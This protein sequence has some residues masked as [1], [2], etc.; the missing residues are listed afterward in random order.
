MVDSAKRTEYLRLVAKI[1]A[2]QPLTPQENYDYTHKYSEYFGPTM[3]SNSGLSNKGWLH[4]SGG[5]AGHAVKAPPYNDQD[6][7]SDPMRKPPPS[8]GLSNK[9]WLHPST[10]IAGTPVKASGGGS[11]GGSFS[12]PADYWKTHAAPGMSSPAYNDQD[13]GSDPMRQPP[14]PFINDRD[15]GSDPMRQGIP[16][17][18]PEIHDPF[19]GGGTGGLITQLPDEQMPNIPQVTLSWHDFT[20]Q[21]R[22]KVAGAYAPLYEAINQGKTNATAQERNSDAV[23][24]G[25]Y[26]QLNARN[27]ADKVATGRQYDAEINATKA[28]NTALEDT[29]RNAGA[30]A[31]ADLAST[32]AAAGLGGHQGTAAADILSKSVGQD[33]AAG[34]AAKTQGNVDLTNVRSQKT[35]Q[36]DYITNTAAADRQQGEATREGLVNQLSQVLQNYDQQRL[37]TKGDEAQQALSLNQQ[38]GQNDFAAQQGSNSNTWNAYNAAMGQYQSKVG[39]DQANVGLANDATRAQIEAAQKQAQLEQNQNQ[40]DLT[41]GQTEAKNAAD[42]AQHQAEMRTKD[43]LDAKKLGISVEDATT[44][45]INA[46]TAAARNTQ[47]TN[48]NA[49]GYDPMKDTTSPQYLAAHNPVAIYRNSLLGFLKSPQR[50]DTM[51]SIADRVFARMNVGGANPSQ[52]AFTNELIKQ[53]KDYGFTPTEAAMA[54]EAFQRSQGSSPTVIPSAHY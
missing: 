8:S 1:K 46:E 17:A 44:R 29:I 5:I 30:S 31:N 34:L 2:N 15:R 35:N 10:G 4:S 20:N 3:H 11:V 6:R 36:E 53:A 45:R 52:T 27:T 38:M 54:A 12:N 48:P 18:G 51:Q 47:G 41:F 19:P 37:Q 13:R 14:P 39:T 26:D 23:I 28:D 43:E 25:M 42:A 32:M 7:G 33:S 49:P 24:K 50:A 9:G 21:A 16:G 40:F 22:Q